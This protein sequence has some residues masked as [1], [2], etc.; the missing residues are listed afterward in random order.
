MRAI[1]AAL[2]ASSLAVPTL[3]RAD[4]MLDPGFGRDGRVVTDFPPDGFDTAK[5][6]AALPD[7]RIVAAGSSNFDMAVARYLPSGDL[8]PSFGGTGRVKVD[9]NIGLP[10]S[11]EA[12]AVLLQPDGRIVLVGRSDSQ[13]HA[14]AR[15]N[16]DGTLDSTFG[17]GG[18]VRTLL[19]SAVDPGTAGVLL[20]DGRI[21]VAGT[22][23]PADQ[24]KP[25]LARYHPDG[26]LDSTFG[27]SGQVTVPLAVRFRVK[28]VAVQADGTTLV[29]GFILVG[30]AGAMRFGVVRLLPNGSLDP[31]FDGDGLVEVDLGTQ[32]APE[33]VEVL[34]GGGILVGGS[35]LSP[36]PN[37][38]L[39]MVK[40]L[41]TGALDPSFGSN[42]VATADPG[43]DRSERGGWV[44]VQPDGKLMI[45]GFAVETG[46]D[47]FLERFHADGTLDVSFGEFGFLRT[48]FGGQD[49]P[50][51]IA[52]AGPDR[53]VLAG[54]TTG[55]PR[56]D[57]F[58]L[59]RY[60]ATTPVELI[61]FAVE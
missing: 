29:A 4:G 47:F 11:D 38:D 22:V 19:P 28:D 21:L 56:P 25:A 58:A 5:A 27:T 42:G 57:D 52:L 20:A 30:T 6:V 59:A 24:M 36:A 17:T 46:S 2:L 39:V 48:D 12:R 54:R 40:L 14:L 53:I 18:L 44:L 1:T 60:I 10:I 55:P 16:T 37:F 51:A 26:S 23:G 31:A 3:V 45:A 49:E 61:S 32:A 33:S 8:D 13:Q 9:F 43:P 41:P 50:A 35:R 34:A 15:L 7:G